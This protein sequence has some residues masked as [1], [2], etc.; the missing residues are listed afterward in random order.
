MDLHGHQALRVGW[1]TSSPT[2]WFLRLHGFIYINVALY[3]KWVEK[4]VG[5]RTQPPMDI[6]AIM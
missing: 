6:H 2:G 3:V 1:A 5:A 4:R